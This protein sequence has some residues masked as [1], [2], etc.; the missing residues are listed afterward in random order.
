M[1]KL[2]LVEQSQMKKELPQFNVGDIVNVV[3]KIPEQD[4]VRLH[5]F[6]GTVIA[7]RQRGAG[8]TFT[9][10]KISYGE[11]IERIFALHSPNIEKIEV[12]RHGKVRRAKL[13]YLRK[14]IGKETK[15]KTTKQI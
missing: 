6:E 5:S 2:T 7:K 13:Y 11:G 4:K 12:V 1:N 3:V 15:I 10:R 14:K 9:I 8:S